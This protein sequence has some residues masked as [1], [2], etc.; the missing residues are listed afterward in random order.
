MFQIRKKKALRV[1]AGGGQLA[2]AALGGGDPRALDVGG[3]GEAAALAACPAAHVDAVLLGLLPDPSSA[4]PTRNPNPPD[5]DGLALAGASA[6]AD[7]EIGSRAA[8]ARSP[9][10]RSPRFWTGIGCSLVLVDLARAGFCR[11]ERK[12]QTFRVKLKNGEL[13]F[14]SREREE[15]GCGN[16][17]TGADRAE[18]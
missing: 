6:A 13:G 1:F 8:I 17:W 4:P 3:A 16:Y 5:P 18:R 10:C 2:L 12:N 7:D 15:E 14:G 11:L 9:C